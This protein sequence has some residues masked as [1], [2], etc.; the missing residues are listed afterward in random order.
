MSWFEN[1]SYGYG[2]GDPG[3]RGQVVMTA[4]PTRPAPTS[5]HGPRPWD[6]PSCLD[7]SR[8]AGCEKIATPP[9]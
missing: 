9:P 2:S 3:H 5:K 6:T 8:I 1:R 7:S 4:G